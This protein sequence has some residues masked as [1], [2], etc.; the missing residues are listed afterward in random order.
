MK[1]DKNGLGAHEYVDF[2]QTTCLRSF[3][4]FQSFSPYPNCKIAD[5]FAYSPDYKCIYMIANAILNS[6]RHLPDYEY[7]CKI[8]NLLERLQ[9]PLNDCNCFCKLANDH[10]FICKIPNFFVRLH[11]NLHDC[12]C[13]WKFANAF[14]W[15]SMH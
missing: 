1:K 12:K 10:K 4:I 14:A 5:L 11:I 7:I 2:D 3:Y 6:Q 8:A 9:T 13:F 15:L